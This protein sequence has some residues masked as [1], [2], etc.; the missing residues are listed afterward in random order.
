MIHLWRA[1]ICN[2]IVLC[3]Y[4]CNAMSTDA[5]VQKVTGTIRLAVGDYDIRAMPSLSCHQVEALSS[6]ISDEET[7]I[8]N[9]IGVNTNSL[10][11]SH[12]VLTPRVQR[13]N[14]LISHTLSKL[15]LPSTPPS[16]LLL[17]HLPEPLSP[18]P[19]ADVAP[20]IVGHV[21]H[22]TFLVQAGA[23]V[24]RAIAAGAWAGVLPTEAR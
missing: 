7:F 24:C 9:D 21:S 14:P 15:T 16:P 23:P 5:P 4:T 2:L 8:N 20:S 1:A 12:T 3:M 17:L 10:G 6:M 13:P 22:R 11:A 18:V 19:S